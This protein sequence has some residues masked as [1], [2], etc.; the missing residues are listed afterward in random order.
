LRQAIATAR[1]DIAVFRFLDNNDTGVRF[2]TRHGVPRTRVATAMLFTLPGIPSLY[3]GQD[4][5]ASYEPYKTSNPIVWS[6][7]ADL[8]YWHA[9]L[10][11]LRR[12]H[13]TLRSRDICFLDVGPADQVL[14]YGRPGTTADDDLIVLLNY[15]AEPTPIKLSRSA[16]RAASGGHLVDLLSGRDFVADG[17]NVSVPLAGHE[18]LIL[19]AR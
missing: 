6:E 8:Q 4:V 7:A 2:V 3:T 16:V 13:A 14:A 17:E 15:G 5:G 11:A 10:I 12:T 18:T 1:G 9:R 19:Q